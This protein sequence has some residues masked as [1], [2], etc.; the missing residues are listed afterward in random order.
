MNTHYVGYD[1][2]HDYDSIV[3][4]C[5][6]YLSTAACNEVCS[7]VSS[8][9]N[10]ICKPAP[11]VSSPA[12]N[13]SC[14]KS[15][16][17]CGQCVIPLVPIRLWWMGRGRMIRKLATAVGGEAC[18]WDSGVPGSLQAYTSWSNSLIKCIYPA[19]SALR[20]VLLFP[21]YKIIPIWL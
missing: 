17:W 10:D 3:C 20:R 18:L 6:C 12:E 14:P 1:R 19:D 16:R 15:T 11:G 13:G 7:Y 4:N 21:S 2:T 8:L 9:Q 5:T